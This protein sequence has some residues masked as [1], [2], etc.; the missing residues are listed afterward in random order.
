MNIHQ[1][2]KKTHHR[3]LI[4]WFLKAAAFMGQNT[5][6]GIILFSTFSFPGRCLQILLSE[7]EWN[8][9]SVII[10]HEQQ[11]LYNTLHKHYT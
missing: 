11:L 6:K 4:L 9:A 2:G 5:G 7:R 1:L 3:H 8:T 10:T